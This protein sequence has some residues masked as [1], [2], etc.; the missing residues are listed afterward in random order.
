[1]RTSQHRQHLKPVPRK[2]A[3]SEDVEEE[4]M[5]STHSLKNISCYIYL[6]ALF[7]CMKPLQAQSRNDGITAGD[8]GA[9]TVAPLRHSDIV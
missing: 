6:V 2:L 7:P 3:C 9:V 4:F 8:H 1:M 5:H